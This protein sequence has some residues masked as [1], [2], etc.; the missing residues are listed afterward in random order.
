M[1]NATV[2]PT[3]MIRRLIL[4]LALIAGIAPAFA[5]VPPPVPALPDAE[6]RTTYS[7][8]SATC[9]CAVGFQL[10]GD[11]TD[12]ANWLTVWVN[13]VAL[14]QAGNWIIT[15]P[16]GPLSSIS[17]PITD[18]VLT[19]LVPQTG[20]VQIVG[21]RRPRR[22]SQ[23]S[24]NAGVSARDINQVISDIVSE[25][26]ELWDRQSRT[27]QAP[28]GETINVLQAMSL[29]ASM[30][31]CF[32]SGGNLIPCVPVA[33]SFSA[34]VGIV[35]TGTNPT[36]IAANI[37]AGAGLKLGGNAATL[38]TDPSYLPGFM[39]GFTMSN[40][41]FLPNT[42]ID[43]AAGVAVSDDN[44]TLM[45]LGSFSKSTAAWAV[46]SSSGCLDTGA[47]ANSTWY[48]LYVIARTD[49]GAVDEVCSTSAT[50]PL[51]PSPYTVKRRVG[52]FKTNG[53]AQILAFTQN[54]KQFLW[55]ATT[56]DVNVGT[57]G[58]SASTF[59][60]NV[61]LGIKVNALTKTYIGN[62]AAG[63]GVNLYSP[64]EATP[65]GFIGITQ[66]ANNISSQV[67]V[68]TDVAQHVIAKS[69]AASTTLAIFT[70]GWEDTGLTAVPG[71]VSAVLTSPPTDATALLQSLL[72]AGSPIVIPCNGTV[73]NV[74]GLTIPAAGGSIRGDCPGATL[75]LTINATGITCT[76]PN[77]NALN[78]SSL[79]ITGTAANYAGN[80]TD[81]ADLGQ[82]G[83][84]I[85]DC[86][87]VTVRGVNFFN[88]SGAGLDC[89]APSSGFSIGGFNT[90]P[91][92]SQT[93][94]AVR[95]GL[96]CDPRRTLPWSPHQP[97]A[98]KLL[99]Q[100][101]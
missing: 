10:Y 19:F 83:I 39:G 8:S 44:S 29:R 49:T 48:H 56:T 17:R 91:S 88:L 87:K 98:I 51:M 11:G 15:S 13:G 27:V 63:I 69:A 54:G 30:G 37:Q 92:G 71:P 5:Q 14:P 57:L 46:G 45:K 47:V 55:A 32:D 3:T 1:K 64:D 40:D 12:V 67:S 53:S 68:R 25:N 7:L 84:H 16:T 21:A 86:T 22:T 76:G 2:V 4:S 26:R 9:A 93:A 77:S 60:L 73:W 28:P 24:E 89:E 33:G 58:T 65:G 82:R 36:S 52:S 72:N 23:F 85:T 80:S 97:E 38:L 59:T 78:I 95:C 99:S 43:T 50:N 61:P 101:N 41:G 74:T 34:G 62:A 6:R 31:A 70:Y 75:H 35:F 90:L 79:T 20:T 42:V 94:R 81:I 18:A 100:N 96:Q 66:T